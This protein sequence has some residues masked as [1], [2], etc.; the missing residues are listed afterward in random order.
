MEREQ[1]TSFVLFPLVQIFIILYVVIAAL[2]CSPTIC[3]YLLAFIFLILLF[4][5]ECY[6]SL[7]IVH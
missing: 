7:C 4:G 2:V 5:Y 1:Y 3:S 6:L